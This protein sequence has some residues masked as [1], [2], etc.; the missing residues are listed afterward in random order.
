MKKLILLVMI[1]LVSGC[2]I[3]RIDTTDVD[4]IVSVVLSKENNLYNQICKGYKYYIPRVVSYIDSNDYNDTL[5]SNGNYYYLF[6]DVVSYF[7][8]KENVYQINNNAYYS[9]EFNVNGKR[10]Y[11]EI[12]EENGKYL[13]EFSYNYSKI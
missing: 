2:S 6:I 13:I 11:L 4:N 10:A 8:N 1:L 5:Y 7:Y 12:N 3:V 9:K